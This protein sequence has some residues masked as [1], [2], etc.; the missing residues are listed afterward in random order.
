M[1]LLL[2][3]LLP[4]CGWMLPAPPNLL[5]PPQPPWAW[6]CAGCACCHPSNPFPVGMCPA[7]AVLLHRSLSF[8]PLL[9]LLLGPPP[10]PARCSPL[11]QGVPSPSTAPGIAPAQ[12]EAGQVV[13]MKR[14]VY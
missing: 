3:W 9:T 7:G 11:C 4:G 13:G 12:E 1:L 8:S 5:L 14:E 6:S 10:Q 2:L